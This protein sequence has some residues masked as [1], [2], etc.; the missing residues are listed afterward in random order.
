MD[1]LDQL[2]LER[3][4]QGLRM[5]LAA[6]I[7]LAG[8]VLI[9]IQSV[10]LPPV[11]R[12][13]LS[14]L[15]ITIVLA[16]LGFLRL[17]GQMRAVRSIGTTGALLDVVLMACSP[18]LWF[19]AL[20]ADAPS[21][22][23]LLSTP[24][25]MFTLAFIVINAMGCRPNYPL[26]V[27][28]G[29]VFIHIVL[30]LLA[31]RDPA[32]VWS[33]NPIDHLVRGSAS[34]AM[35]INRIVVV[36][37][38]GAAS[39]WITSVARRTIDEGVRLE[40]KNLGLKEQQAR[41]TMEQKV[42]AYGRLVAGISHEINNPMGAIT[43]ALDTMSRAVTRLRDPETEARKRDKSLAAIETSTAVAAAAAERVT[44][45]VDRL[46]RFARLDEAD[47]QA[48]DINAALEASASLVPHA[49]RDYV[50]LTVELQTLPQIQGS[51]R[52]LNQAFLTILTNAFEAVKG[53]H[54]R[55]RVTISTWVGDSGQIEIAIE[56]TGRG[57]SP[58]DIE[59]LF[60]IDFSVRGDRI[61]AGLG[62]P[63]AQS[64]ILR[65]GGDVRVQSEVGKGTRFHIELPV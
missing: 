36:A 12:V 38:V 11:L 8:Y 65:H 39:T 15:Q 5:P 40:R 57:I 28:V 7:L 52:E 56:D 18:V 14:V 31:W 23:Y 60:D 1:R 33:N 62:L 50:E 35:G 25:T 24:V 45:T 6:R 44:I 30:Y 29:G 34:H 48:L 19:L 49:L 21:R 20:D 54:K 64:V 55:A 16:N 59:R 37:L 42:S 51:A 63:A 27:S 53:D 22:G 17:L 9:V 26:I 43:S 46:K 32:T 58:Q 4:A 10:D 13:G 47:L 2:F 61:G 41:N 3:E